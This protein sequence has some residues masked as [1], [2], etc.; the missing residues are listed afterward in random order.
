MGQQ[1]RATK[2]EKYTEKNSVQKSFYENSYL[3]MCIATTYR[4]KSKRKKKTLE[5]GSQGQ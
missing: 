2:C 4:M 5:K 1:Q 3:L